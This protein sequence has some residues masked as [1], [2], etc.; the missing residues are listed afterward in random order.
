[1]KRNNYR[2]ESYKL[3]Y[4]DYD[5]LEENGCFN[6]HTERDDLKVDPDF[7]NNM[8]TKLEIFDEID[9]SQT[10]EHTKSIR[11]DKWYIE[12][13]DNHIFDFKPDSPITDDWPKF[14]KFINKNSREH[15]HFSCNL[16]GRSIRSATIF[17]YWFGLEGR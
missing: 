8:H 12:T 5:D 4:L 13:K 14:L 1:M 9:I 17:K 3:H 16:F 7:F 2:Y 15:P 10:S 11:T 6:E